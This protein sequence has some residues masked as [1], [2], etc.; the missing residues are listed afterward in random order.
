MSTRPQDPFVRLA[1]AVGD[2]GNPFYEEERQRDVWNEAS[3]FGLQLLL[4]TSLLAAT[5]TVWVVGAA[6]VPYV[7][8]AVG[9]VG[10]VS[11]LTMAYAQRL[12]VDLTDGARVL[13]WRLLPYLGLLLA[14]VAGVLRARAGELSSSFATG[15][16]GGA[17]LALLVVVV[18]LRRTA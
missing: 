11:G 4:W 12:G 17:A 10:V 3:A 2:F 8:G 9:L 15:M 18:R 6:A 16:L 1:H 5:A 7:L 14:L 13:R